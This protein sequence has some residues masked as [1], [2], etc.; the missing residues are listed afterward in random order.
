MGDDESWQ[1]PLRITLACLF[2]VGSA[3]FSGL[4]L[5]LMTLDVMQLR[6][7]MESGE[8]HPDPKAT[9]Y[10]TM[11]KRIYRVRKDGNFL[12]V[13]LLLGN[14]MV[15]SALSITM[16]DLA[17]GLVGFAISTSVIT[18]FGEILPQAICTRYGL[19]AGYYL[20]PLV[21]VFEV[22]FF[23][24]GKPIALF[25]DWILGQEMGT[26][27]TK[28][29]LKAIVNIHERE[30]KV[31]T[32]EEARI[33]GG[34]LEFAL[35]ATS[36]A[37]TPMSAV[38]GLDAS[39]RFTFT[40]ASSIIASGFSRIP[41][42]DRTKAQCVVGMLMVKDL[43]LLDPTVEMPVRTLLQVFG[44]TVYV[45]DTDT[46]LFSLLTDFKKG[47]THLA[48]VRRVEEDAAGG[49]PYYVHVGIITLEDIIE[50]ILQD[51]IVDEYEHEMQ[52][53][54]KVT[55]QLCSD[56]GVQLVP[57]AAP[58]GGEESVLHAQE[59]RGSRKSDEA[60]SATLGRIML[61]VVS[62]AE[63]FESLLPPWSFVCAKA[64]GPPPLALLQAAAAETP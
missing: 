53:A 10:A 51:E 38:F 60:M 36:T 37:M 19:L 17:G 26:R 45:V 46:P 35:K 3:V 15:N 55:G 63:A 42:F 56:S 23:P 27:F 1:L 25:L 16:G 18:L 29:Q 47:R 48:V 8:T 58:Y 40:L 12:L 43:L 44:R 13:T 33:L 39:D 64:L 4:T 50:E 20:F 31:L 59:P 21:V 30:A 41:V 52:C 6:M 24:I 34:G 61:R 14:V 5:G 7:L 54:A 57:S 9:K 22:L 49:D 2:G 11:A 32:K 28:S 62:G